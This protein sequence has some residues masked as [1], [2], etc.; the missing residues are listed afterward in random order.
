MLQNFTSLQ[1]TLGI[2]ELAP[3]IFYVAGEGVNGGPFAIFS[4]DMRPFLI[5]PNGTI[6]TPPIVKEIG[7]IPS[8]L[9]LNGMT[10]LR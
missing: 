9:Q 7:S 1:N 10:C 6:F 4:V 3:D 8:S 2:T 5:L